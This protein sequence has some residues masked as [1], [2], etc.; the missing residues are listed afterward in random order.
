MFIDLLQ[1][2]TVDTVATQA[3]QTQT[4]QT[5]TQPTPTLGTAQSNP[6][7]TTTQTQTTPEPVVQSTHM[8]TPLD[9]SNIKIT[10]GGYLE[11]FTNKLLTSTT[12]SNGS[13]GTEILDNYPKDANGDLLA[14]S[15]NGKTLP[16]H[17]HT[18]DYKLDGV[19]KPFIVTITDQD[20][21]TYTHTFN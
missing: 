16:F 6:Q 4:T 13:I 14:I 12:V 5:N 20:G 19:Q 3:T 9:I 8:P 15:D 10:T 11:I 18:Y 17:G 7:P 1:S 21:L 2:F